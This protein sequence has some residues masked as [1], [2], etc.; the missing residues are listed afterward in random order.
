MAEEGY[1]WT[2]RCGND[3]VEDIFVN[4][5]PLFFLPQEQHHR[6]MPNEDSITNKFVTSTLYSGPRI[7]DIANALALVEPL[8]HPVPEISK[9]TVPRLER[10]TLNK[11]DKYTLKV[12]NNSNGMCDDGYKWRKY[13]QKSIKNSPNPRS[14]YKCTNPICNAKKQVERSID[15]PNTYIITYEGFHFHYTYPFFLPDKT[16]QWPNKKTKIHKYYAQEMNKGSQT[17]EE[18]KEAQLGE[19]ANQNQPVHKAQENTPV[20]LEDELFFPVDQC[21]RQQGLLEDVV[22][23]AMKNIPT[24]DSVLTASWSSLSSYTSSSLSPSSLCWSPNFDIVL[25]DEIL[26]LI[27]SRKF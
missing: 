11:V 13:G 20:N 6:L 10:S 18:S 26:E 2:R 24:K 8:S 27:G 15:E 14:Y 23:P 5:P 17:Q 25:S 9:S 1:Q 19:P 3:A 22:A 4:E 7:Q 12:K 16:H 21:R